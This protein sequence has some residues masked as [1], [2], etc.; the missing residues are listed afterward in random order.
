MK[1]HHRHFNNLRATVCQTSG[2]YQR[3]KLTGFYRTLVQTDLDSADLRFL[4]DPGLDRS[5]LRRPEVQG[6]EDFSHL[7]Q[8]EELEDSP[9]GRREESGVG[10]GHLE[11]EGMEEAVSDV[12]QGVLVHV[13]IS[14]PVGSHVVVVVDGHIVVVVGLVLRHDSGSGLRCSH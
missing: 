10:D 11:E 12:D 4:Q 3:N 1:S 9:E 2:R 14:D 13:G 5:G 8:D 6:H 7:E